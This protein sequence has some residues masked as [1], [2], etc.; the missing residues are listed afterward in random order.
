MTTPQRSALPDD[1]EELDFDIEEE[2]W[3][4][5][6]L[7]DN[8]RVRIRTIL[9]KIMRNPNNPNEFS[10]NTQQPIFVIYAPVA[11][12]GERNNALKCTYSIRDTKNH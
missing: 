9:N 8:S 2:S 3:N 5:Y 4:E 7:S 6:E 1:F 10:F 11:S 12:R